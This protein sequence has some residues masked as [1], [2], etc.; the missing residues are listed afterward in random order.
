MP[1]SSRRM[2]TFLASCS[3]RCRSE[4]PLSRAT[5]ARA[6]NSKPLVVNIP[7]KT[8]EQMLLTAILQ[9]L[10]SSCEKVSNLEC[11][12]F[13]RI[14]TVRAI[15]QRNYNNFSTLPSAC[16]A[17][18]L[19]VGRSGGQVLGN[20]VCSNSGQR[21]P[22]G[23]FADFY[24]RQRQDRER[25]YPSLACSLITLRGSLSFRKPANFAWRKWLS[26]ASY[27]TSSLREPPDHRPKDCSVSTRR[28]DTTPF[29]RCMRIP[30]KGEA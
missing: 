19:I 18:R 6:A 14:G 10:I 2:V 3:Q 24:D 20:G 30:P 4:V 26:Y 15:C 8:T 21:Y 16:G 12:G 23:R 17:A 9:V 7:A 13:R 1:Q 25:A 11:G 5:A 28:D 22:H 29:K 27:C